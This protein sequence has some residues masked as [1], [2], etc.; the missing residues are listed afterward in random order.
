MKQAISTLATL[1][2][3]GAGS[4]HAAD[5]PSQKAT[6][7]IPP[8]AFTWSGLYAGLNI[9]G[10]FLDKGGK[11]G[12][13]GGGQI[14]YNY[15]I[16][17][18]FVVGLETD[19]QGTSLGG[20]S[21]DGFGPPGLRG[22]GVDWFGTLRG[23]AGVTLFD[24]HLL[25]YGTGGFAYGETSGGGSVSTGWTAGGGLEWA[26]SP[27]W[28][29]KVEYLYTDLGQ[30]GGGFGPAPDLAWLGPERASGAKFHTIRAGVNYRFDLL[31]QTFQ[32]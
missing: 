22:R 21:S 7:F 13:L 9:G 27:A 32:R 25:A 15:Q 10:G 8:P 28:S 30:S 4:A 19:F 20:G 18:L 3:L 11:N 24:P 1:A 12:V 17:P 5:L 2:A 26:F 6:V 16:A 14:G 29:T 31:S 23:R